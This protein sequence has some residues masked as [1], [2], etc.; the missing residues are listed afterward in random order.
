MAMDIKELFQMEIKKITGMLSDKYKPSK[1]IIFGASATGDVTENSDIDMLVI[2]DTREN[3]RERWMNVCKLAR[4]FKRHIPFEPIII[5]PAEL[6]NRLAEG[7]L[8]L[9]EIID[10]GKIVYERE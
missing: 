4:D 1:M 7:D 10:H 8:F 5:T 2:K 6:K 3:L 9:K